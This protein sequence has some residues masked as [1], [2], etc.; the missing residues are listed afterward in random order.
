MSEEEKE[1]IERIKYNDIARPLHCGDITICNI[2]DLQTVLNLVQKQQTEL[3]KLK[4]KNKELLRKLRNRVKEVKKLNKYSL[5][6]KE[7][8]KL[9]R[10]IEKKDKII[11]KMA[12]L[13]QE[14]A[15]STPGTTFYYL[16]KQG[17]DDSKCENCKIEKCCGD[18]IKQYFKRKVEGE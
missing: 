17:F 12:K 14:I 4:N 13:I 7:F 5:Y 6:K 11:D 18:C 8:A 1:A 2:E 10:E 15:T 3:E 16:R 9:N